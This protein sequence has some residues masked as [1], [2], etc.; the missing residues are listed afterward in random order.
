MG[1]REH[2]VA[3]PIPTA[4]GACRQLGSPTRRGYRSGG[5]QEKRNDARRRRLLSELLLQRVF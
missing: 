1:L 3:S 4:R 5:D 2:A